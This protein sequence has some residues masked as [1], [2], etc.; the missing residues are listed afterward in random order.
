MVTREYAHDF[1]TRLES[2]KEHGC[3][4]LVTG[5]VPEEGRVLATR[6]LL[7]ASAEPRR[8]ILVLGDDRPEP[9]LPGGV[10][11]SDDTVRVLR[12][13]TADP[14]GLRELVA[15][16]AVELEPPGGYHPGEL[17]IGIPCF[18]EFHQTGSL[19]DVE[20]TL[21]RLAAV[22]RETRGMGHCTL[23]APDDDGV[24]AELAD[25]FDARIELRTTDCLEQRWHLDDAS[26]WFEL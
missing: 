21:N 7:G 18:G 5:D 20:T 17:R 6:R 26:G 23:A 11:P 13:D 3:S 8:R 25:D 4:L 9:Y 1:T 2:L 19:S 15:D 10:A 14:R 12:P 22:C 16:A 24:V